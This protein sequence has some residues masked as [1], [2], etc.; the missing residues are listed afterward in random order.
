[1]TS[2]VSSQSSCGYEPGET[3]PQGAGDCNGAC[4]KGQAACLIAD[5]TPVCG[6]GSCSSATFATW[7]ATDKSSS[8]S[9]SN[10][11]L[12]AMASSYQ[13][14][15]RATIGKSTGRWY[16]E[17]TVD[18]T[19]SS[20]AAVG[21]LTMSALF[22]YGLGNSSIAPGIGFSPSGSISVSSGSSGSACGYASGNVI[23]VALDLVSRAIYFSVNG[24]WQGGA[25]PAASTGGLALGIS[26]ESMYPAVSLGV[27]D[28]LTVNFGQGPFAHAAP[29][30]FEAV[31]Q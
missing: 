3:C 17:V 28:V 16:W 27:G 31:A 8:V 22:D 5:C 23:G 30:G 12:T 1:M 20:Y 13:V 24:L 7:S 19:S 15:A 10:G 4:A 25:D 9:L 11:D 26:G 6:G 14:A 2:R 21:V 18:N 29:S